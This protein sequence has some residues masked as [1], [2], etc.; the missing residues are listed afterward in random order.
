MTRLLGFYCWPKILL[1]WLSCSLPNWVDK[2]SSNIRSYIENKQKANSPIFF[3]ETDECKS[4]PCLNGG[5][6]VD[7][8]YDFTCV[9]LSA[10]IGKRCEGSVTSYNLIIGV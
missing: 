9:C 4:S 10:F 3:T 5:T 1:K 8:L 6:C 7:G 2:R